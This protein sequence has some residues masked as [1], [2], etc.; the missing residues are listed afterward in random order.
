MFCICFFTLISIF[1]F[2]YLF[3]IIVTFFYITFELYYQIGTFMCKNYFACLGIMVVNIEVSLAPIQYRRYF[4]KVLVSLAIFLLV[5]LEKCIC[6]N[7]FKQKNRYFHQYFY[8]L[9]CL[10]IYYKLF[11]FFLLFYLCLRT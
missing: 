1:L 5:S 8:K 4:F 2:N 7:F 6:Q 10:I 3:I 9:R 11:G